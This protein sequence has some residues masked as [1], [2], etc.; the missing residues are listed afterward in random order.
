[1]SCNLTPSV[2]FDL[3]IPIHG[4]KATRSSFQ[5]EAVLHRHFFYFF[6]KS[7]QKSYNIWISGY[8]RMT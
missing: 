5:T 4:Y 3:V 1:L 6:Q 7:V 2:E 8:Y